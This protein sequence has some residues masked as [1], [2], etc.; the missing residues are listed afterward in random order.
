MKR[1]GTGSGVH[2]F[3]LAFEHTVDILNTDFRCADVM[4]FAWTQTWQYSSAHFLIPAQHVM[5]QNNVGL[6]GRGDWYRNAWQ[7][8]RL[9][10]LFAAVIHI[11]LSCSFRSCIFSVPTHLPRCNKRNRPCCHTR[12]GYT[13]FVFIHNTLRL[14]PHCSFKRIPEQDSNYLTAR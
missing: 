7:C 10:L 3:E 11:L 9:Q 1:S 5:F 12:H 4:P 2:V 6:L 14:R 8:C 13:V